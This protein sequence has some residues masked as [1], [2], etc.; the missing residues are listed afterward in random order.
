MPLLMINRDKAGI[1][2]DIALKRMQGDKHRRI[3]MIEDPECTRYP[4]PHTE[5]FLDLADDCF[6]WSLAV[7][8]FSARKLPLSREVRITQKA[9]GNEHTTR[10]SR[11]PDE[12][13]DNIDSRFFG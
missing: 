10:L 2:C 1:E 9:P 3:L 8:D 5:L 13:T 12:G 7:L 4:N 6:R 11:V